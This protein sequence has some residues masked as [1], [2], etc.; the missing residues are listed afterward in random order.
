LALNPLVFQLLGLLL[1]RTGLKIFID[2]PSCCAASLGMAM[3]GVLA[4]MV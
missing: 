4:L 3:Y 1:R 2:A